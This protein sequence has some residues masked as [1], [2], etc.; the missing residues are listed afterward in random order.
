L[1]IASKSFDP[2]VGDRVRRCVS[3]VLNILSA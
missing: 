3:L 1:S 2:R